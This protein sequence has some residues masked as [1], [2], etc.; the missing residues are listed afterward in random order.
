MICNGLDLH[1]PIKVN[2]QERCQNK[3]SKNVPIIDQE[4]KEH[5]G[6]V[7]FMFQKIP[8]YHCGTGEGI[9]IINQID[10]I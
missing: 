5:I 2:P 8:N 6:V 3:E 4:P 10:K 1:L 9:F 7:A